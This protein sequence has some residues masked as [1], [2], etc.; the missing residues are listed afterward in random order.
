MI[1][2]PQQPPPD[3]VRAVM[4]QIFARPEYQWRIRRNVLDVIRA[5]WN[6]LMDVLDRMSAAHP[7]AFIAFMLVLTLIVALLFTHIAFVLRRALRRAPAAD[8]DGSAPLPAARDATWHMGQ[9]RRLAA[10][11]R[12]TEALGHRFLALVLELERRRAV[13]VRAS[14]TPAEYAREARLDPGGRESLGALVATLYAMLFGG[15][16]CDAGRLCGIRPP[17]GGAGPAC[18]SSLSSASSCCWRRPSRPSG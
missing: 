10:A 4:R 3:S 18:A 9:A 16:P 15:Q 8:G 17:G 12:F 2:A 13:A 14:K 11:G 5:Y 7:V 1:A 6:A